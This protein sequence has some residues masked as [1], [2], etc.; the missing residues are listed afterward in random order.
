ME[1]QVLQGEFEAERQQLSRLT[2]NDLT[3]IL[4]GSGADGCWHVLL[5]QPLRFFFFQKV[6]FR[7]LLCLT[8]HLKY[9][10]LTNRE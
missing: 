6:W 9:L 2:H 7:M 1:E 3:D 4:R 10:L 5:P 8:L